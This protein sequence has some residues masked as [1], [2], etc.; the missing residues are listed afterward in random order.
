[1]IGE[2]D[3]GP[4]CHDGRVL[5]PEDLGIAVKQAVREDVVNPSRERVMRTIAPVAAVV[6]EALVEARQRVR[7]R[8]VDFA[9]EGIADLCQRR[10]R[11]VLE[12][13]RDAVDERVASDGH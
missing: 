6:A 9:P 1:M 12:K 5:E 13:R 7:A 8:R 3:D 2:D 11:V 4:S 10:W